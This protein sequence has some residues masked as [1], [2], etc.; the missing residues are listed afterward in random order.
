MEGVLGFTGEV[1]V[2]GESVKKMD[3]YANEVFISVFQQ[4][5]LVCRLASEEMEK[6]YC[7]RGAPGSNAFTIFNGTTSRPSSSVTGS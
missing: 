4:S 5:G 1:N 3:I 7:F 6:P 2:Q